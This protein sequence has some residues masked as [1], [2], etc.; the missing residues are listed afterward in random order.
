MLQHINALVGIRARDEVHLAEHLEAVDHRQH[1]HEEYG[2][3]EAGKRD[4]AK[5]A[6][7]ARAVHRRGFIVARGDFAKAREVKHHHIP[8][9]FPEINER[10]D[11]HG[12]AA[13]QKV[14]FGDAKRAE[15]V[16]DRAARREQDRPEYRH[17]GHRHNKRRDI[18][19][20]KQAA[21]LADAFYGDGNEQRQQNVERH[22]N[23]QKQQRVFQCQ[24]KRF[25]LQRFNKVIEAQCAVGSKGVIQAP[26]EWNQKEDQKTE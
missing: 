17:G 11:E 24:L 6:V 19:E 25:V 15:Y 14:R 20:P 7:S 2:G 26:D 8:N 3:P 21:A 5:L 4:V 13:V 1:K 16:V 23:E 12:P 9:V 10:D 18:R 22:A